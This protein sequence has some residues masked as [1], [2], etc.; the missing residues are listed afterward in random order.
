[1][2]TLATLTDRERYA[3][4][5]AA[6]D[7]A[8]TDP[9]F[10][11]R[12][13]FFLDVDLETSEEWGAIPDRARLRLGL[14]RA[15]WRTTLAASKRLAGGPKGPGLLFRRLAARARGE[16][17]PRDGEALARD[18]R[19]LSDLLLRAVAG[20]LGPIDR[21]ETAVEVAEAFEAFAAGELLLRG[22]GP[23]GPIRLGGE[24]DSAFF[25]FW[26][27]FAALALELEVD[28]P[29]WERWLPALVGAQEV[30]LTAYRPPNRHDG[31]GRACAPVF[32]DYGPVNH[33]GPPGAASRA[34]RLAGRERHRRLGRAGLLE[35]V[36]ERARSSLGL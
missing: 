5:L 7:S 27:E 33:I 29:T 18:V 8:E 25:F 30:F 9:V 26:G 17:L 36:A 12:H 31:A 13:G 3:A 34:E 4:R 10:A 28:G 24:P 1:M 2:Q 32:G 16:A 14:D 35:L 19:H 23:E 20:H 21:D 6:L 22:R 15:R 11:R